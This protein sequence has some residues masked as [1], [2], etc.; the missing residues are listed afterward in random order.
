MGKT[1]QEMGYVFYKDEIFLPV[2]SRRSLKFLFFVTICKAS[3]W[4]FV[5]GFF[6]S[7]RLADS[8]AHFKSRRKWNKLQLLLYVTEG[9][10]VGETELC[11][12]QERLLFS[13][14]NSN[15]SARTRRNNRRC[16]RKISWKQL[17]YIWFLQPLKTKEYNRNI[18]RSHLELNEN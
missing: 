10:V 13:R 18:N 15:N 1:A 17:T 9:K 5:A 14:S 3:N 2:L 16:N 6:F 12:F 11:G 8:I 7:S 4:P